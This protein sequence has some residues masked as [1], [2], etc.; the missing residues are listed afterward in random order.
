M[1]S[2]FPHP[3][4]RLPCAASIG[5]AAVVYSMNTSSVMADLRV[6]NDLPVRAKYALLLVESWTIIL[7][8]PTE[9]HGWVDPRGR[10]PFTLQGWWSVA[11]GACS[12]IEFTGVAW[13]SAW[14]ADPPLKDAEHHSGMEIPLPA[15]NFR[16]SGDG[17]PTAAGSHLVPFGAFGEGFFPVWS[18]GGSRLEERL[19]SHGTSAVFPQD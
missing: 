6:C 10:V 7:L 5:V 19:L 13:G 18:S 14:E 3:R 9:G 11:P 16:I 15:G 1:A 4:Q 17:D 12:K 2:K 8:T